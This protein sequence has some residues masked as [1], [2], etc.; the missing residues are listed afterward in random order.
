MAD[1]IFDA[2][3][4]G[5]QKAATTALYMTLIR[6]SSVCGHPDCKDVPFY[7]GLAPSAKASELMSL[8]KDD[9]LLHLG[10]E[11]NLT[12]CPGG[13]SR[14]AAANPDIKV[15]FVVRAPLSRA[16]SAVAYARQRGLEKR[17]LKNAL[18]EDFAEVI[19]GKQVRIGEW[20][21]R[22]KSYIAHGMYEYDIK[23][24]TQSLS[25]N[26]YMIVSFDELRWEASR[27]L[28][29]L[30]N[31]LQL[32]RE[33]LKFEKANVTTGE[34]RLRWFTALLEDPGEMR[35][36]KMMARRIIWSTSGIKSQASIRKIHPKN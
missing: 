8:S 27:V 30:Q 3:I 21:A 31:Y 36:V 2:Y 4:V 35:F 26:Q 14:L 16:I 19:D 34:P 5:A 9:D 32:P 10:G 13:I 12:F 15:I 11:A 33:D 29:K 18:L 25:T 7:T 23:E 1:K 17:P 24:M 28:D 6:H 20:E 22:Q